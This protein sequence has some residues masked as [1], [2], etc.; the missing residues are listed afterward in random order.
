MKR[1]PVTVTIGTLLL[2]IFVSLL[3]LFQVRQTEIAV[4]TTFGRFSHQAGP[5]AHF[6][7]P[8]PIQSVHHFDQR[9]HNFESK[10]EQ[11]LTADENNLLIQAYVGWNISDAKVFL[12]RFGGDPRKAQ[13]NLEGLIRNAYSG[14]VGRHPFAHFISTDERQLKFVEIEREMQERV[15][16]DCRA[17]TNGLQIHFFGIKR[18]GLPESVTQL[19]FETMRSGRD[20]LASV[21]ESD[22]QR[23][24][25]EIREKAKAEGAKLL[26]EAEAQATRILSEGEK[27][28]ARSFEVFKQEPDLAVFLLKLKALEQFLQERATLILDDQVA[29]L[30]ILKSRQT[31]GDRK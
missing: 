9:I 6:R 15:Q 20:K 21:I 13:E 30:D 1:N 23:Q 31:P 28:T 7:L 16:A 17:V 8:W 14:V 12:E 26:A 27:Q 3:F 29:P 10:L 19:V 18:L 5:G 25:T 24:A 11:I 22:G 2:L 4:V